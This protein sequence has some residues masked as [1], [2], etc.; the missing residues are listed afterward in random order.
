MKKKLIKGVITRV[1]KKRQLVIIL[2]DNNEAVFI[3]SG[4]IK[5]NTSLEINEVELLIG[6][7]MKFDFYQPNDV[8]FNEK[9]CI[10][11]DTLVKE[12]FFEL[13]KPVDKLRVE[14][15]DL[16][17]PYKKISKIFY[18]DKYGKENTGIET[19]DGKVTFLPLKRLEIQSKLNK[20]EQHI[21]VGSYI[22]PEFYE[23]GEILPNGNAINYDN[24]LKWINIR[25]SDSVNGMHKK[26]EGDAGRHS[27]NQPDD[28][29]DGPGAYGYSSWDE[30]TLHV[31]YEGD[32]DNYWNT[33]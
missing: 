22:L 26:F 6:S 15:N 28:S 14:N 27:N 12:Y 24:V 16:L 30:M 31:A 33:D 9:I 4:E 29:D 3:S 7:T 23:K 11:E 17:L 8:M 5:K 25:Y 10:K 13:Q 2:F 32:E 20:S 19:V 18:F 1:I 21:L